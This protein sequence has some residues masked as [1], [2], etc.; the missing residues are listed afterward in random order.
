MLEVAANGDVVDVDVDVVDRIFG[1]VSDRFTV[2]RFGL[3]LKISNWS[4]I[5]VSGV[6]YSIGTYFCIQNTFVHGSDPTT[7]I[8]LIKQ[9]SKQSRQTTRISM[10]CMEL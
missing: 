9:I 5:A 4:D 8:K 2:G 7:Q 3:S 10:Y 1:H 6:F